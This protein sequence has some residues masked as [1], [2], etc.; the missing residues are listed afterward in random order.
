M[1]PSTESGPRP[2]VTTETWSKSL[3]ETPASSRSRP[4][5]TRHAVACKRLS[6]AGSACAPAGYKPLGDPKGSEPAVLAVS[7]LALRPESG[8][9]GETQTVDLCA[10]RHPDGLWASVETETVMAPPAK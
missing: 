4:C 9:V 8:W 7:A 1:C 5:S 3:C 6:P 2:I 10:F